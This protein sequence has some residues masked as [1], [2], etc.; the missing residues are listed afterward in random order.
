MHLG[1]KCGMDFTVVSLILTVITNGIDLDLMSKH[2]GNE[3][4]VICTAE[5]S[6]TT[7]E[8]NY[9]MMDL[10]LEESFVPFRCIDMRENNKQNQR[11]HLVLSTL[12]LLNLL[13]SHL[14]NK[15]KN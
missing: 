15:Q 3:C 8:P 12:S 10:Y 6:E 4:H 9:I 1:L 14:D 11:K 5:M 13:E 2:A 7:V